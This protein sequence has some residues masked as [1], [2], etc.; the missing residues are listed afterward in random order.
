MR[1]T[2]WRPS[3]GGPARRATRERPAEHA[4]RRAYSREHQSSCRRALRLGG[5]CFVPRELGRASLSAS[6]S[7]GSSVRSGAGSPAASV[8]THRRAACLRTTA[9]EEPAASAP[10]D[11]RRR[12]CDRACGADENGRH[13]QPG[14]RSVGL[15]RNGPNPS[16]TTRPSSH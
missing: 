4:S 10:A 9:K 14:I 5:K 11:P 8:C 1:S 3:E 2:R 13:A 12:G 16:V 6:E 15:R 7:S